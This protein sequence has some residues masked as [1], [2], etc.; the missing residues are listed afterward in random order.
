MKYWWSVARWWITRFWASRIDSWCGMDVMSLSRPNG[1]V[2]LI[3]AHG[4]WNL[5][6]AII[7]FCEVKSNASDVLANF[8]PAFSSISKYRIM[9]KKIFSLIGPKNCNIF[10][11]ATTYARILQPGLLENTIRIRL[12]VLKVLSAS[13]PCSLIGV[14]QHVSDCCQDWTTF[15]EDVLDGVKRQEL[16]I[17]LSS[18]GASNI[19]DQRS[20]ILGQI[21]PHH[22]SNNEDSKSSFETT[23]TYSQLNYHETLNRFFDSRPVTFVPDD[24]LKTDFSRILAKKPMMSPV[25]VSIIAIWCRDSMRIKMKQ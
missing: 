5:L 24:S 16:R 8:F 4:N 23:L 10:T 20:E 3:H 17:D 25:H 18:D 9:C 14:V 2:H 7:P 15:M 21:S 1:Q 13:L 12:E 19:L 6:P 22:H 11:T